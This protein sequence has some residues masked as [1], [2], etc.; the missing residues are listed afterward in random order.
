MAVTR[1]TVTGQDKIIRNL[2]KQIVAM[3]ERNRA[4]MSEAALIVKRESMIRTPVKTG[5]LKGSTYT[6][7]VSNMRTGVSGEIGYTAAYAVYVHENLD[8]HHNVGQARF[9]AMALV[10]KERAVL[11]ALRR[12]A[13]IK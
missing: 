9:L 2:N 8:A 7:V 1:I 5:N 12:H 10:A 6:A 13:T 11:E 4:G 3:S